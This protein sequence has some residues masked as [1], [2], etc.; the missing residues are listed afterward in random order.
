VQDTRQQPMQT[1]AHD[2]APTDGIGPERH[3]EPV[4]GLRVLICDAD[5][6]IVQTVQESLCG[7]RGAQVVGVAT[8][9]HEAIELALSQLPDLVLIDPALLDE[10][11]QR[12]VETLSGRTL[13]KV[14]VMTDNLFCNWPSIRQ[15]LPYIA[16]FF[17]KPLGTEELLNRLDLAFYPPGRGCVVHPPVPPRE[18]WVPRHEWLRYYELPRWR[19]TRTHVEEGEAAAQG[20]LRALLT[21]EEY[22]QLTT[23]GYVEV[24]SRSRAERTYRIPCTGGQVRVLEGGQEVLRLCLQPTTMLPR[25]D[26]VLTHKLLLEAD[27]EH[28]LRTAN[29]FTPDGT[30]VARRARR[31]G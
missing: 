2:D 28:Y 6:Q 14:V 12:A 7:Y 8:T 29:H 21:G 31:R 19:G 5:M 3:P 20:V 30:R 11:D 27:E 16:G 18:Q 24:R 10:E 26:V 13:A 9:G 1:P 23:Q 4:R 22:Q 25:G 15:L 17:Q